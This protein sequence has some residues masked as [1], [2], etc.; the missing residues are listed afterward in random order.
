MRRLVVKFDAPV[1]AETVTAFKD[2]VVPLLNEA[3]ELVLLINSSGGMVDLAIELARFLSKIR[4]GIITHNIGRCE[5]A[6]VM[7]FAAG[8]IR[9]AGSFAVFAVHEVSQ[10]FEGMLSLSEVKARLNTM[11]KDEDRI[12]RFLEARTARSALLWE[13]DMHRMRS[14]GAMTANRLGLVT[15]V[16]EFQRMEDDINIVISRDGVVGDE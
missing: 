13:R 15:H 14:F 2:G 8:T 7:M 4:P 9:I 6:A 11:C 3:D 10:Q 12:V 1:T 16:G 5:S